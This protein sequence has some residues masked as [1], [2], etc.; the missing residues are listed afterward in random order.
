[1]SLPENITENL[2]GWIAGC[3]IC[4]D[5]CPWNQSVPKNNTPDVEPKEWINKLDKSSLTWSD[6]EWKKKI[7]GTTLNRIKP[8]MWKRNIKAAIGK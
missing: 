2:N 8:W 6:E 5:V 7:K 3:D 1:M 4:Q